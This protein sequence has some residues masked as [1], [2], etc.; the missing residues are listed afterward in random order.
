[1]T[2]GDP[3]SAADSRCSPLTA[4]HLD[5]VID[6]DRRLTGQTRKGF[7]TR[8]MADAGT[9]DAMTIALVGMSGPT[10]TGYLL[11]RVL[12]G[13]FG[14]VHA[15]AVIDA[16]GIAPDHRGQGVARDL[17]AALRD[18]ARARGVTE[19]RSEA[20]WSE[21]DLIRFFA[22]QGFDLTP[23]QAFER[24][25]GTGPG[26]EDDTDP[27]AAD[28]VTV[29]S[30]T[31]TDL[32]M[33]VTTDQRITGRDRSAYYRHKL[34]EMMGGSGVRLSLVAEIDGAFAGFV[35]ARVDYGDFGR[36]ETTAVI[37]T[38]GVGPLFARRSIGR[39]LLAQLM[40]NLSSLRVDRVGTRL[41]WNEIALRAFLADL[42]FAP[43]PRLSFVRT[44]G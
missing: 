38:I 41:D 21:M 10:P 40:R 13:E 4:D 12:D 28:T 16:I 11:A 1:M 3:M 33:I 9:E 43:R 34:S 2:L 39:A 25:V 32:P 29:R 18:R 17:M 23:H 6:L 30:M 15:A 19:V 42:G 44:L 24:D 26:P 5:A 20:D 37:D 14:D 36:L 22:S 35:M 8:R 27:A 7:F 31:E